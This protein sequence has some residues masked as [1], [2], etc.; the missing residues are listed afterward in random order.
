LKKLAE[1]SGIAFN[2]RQGFDIDFSAAILDHDF[3]I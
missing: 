2:F 3:Q 1:L